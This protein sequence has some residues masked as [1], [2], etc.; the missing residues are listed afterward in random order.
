MRFYEANNAKLKED[1]D[2]KSIIVETLKVD[3]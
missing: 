1:V 3:S 2:A